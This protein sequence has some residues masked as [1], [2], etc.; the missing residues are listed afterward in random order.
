MHRLKQLIPKD[1]CLG[2]DVC[3]RFPQALSSQ[4]PYF[5]ASE[6]KKCPAF[7]PER[8][9]GTHITLTPYQEYFICPNFNPVLNKC[10]IYQ[11]RPF[12]CQLYPFTITYNSTNEEIVLGMD[13]KCPFVLDN[14]T[15]S[16]MENYK[17]HLIRYMCSMGVLNFISKNPKIVG[18]FQ[19][20]II[21]FKKLPI[22]PIHIKAKYH[23]L[24]T[25]TLKDKALFNK[26]FKK[27][28]CDLS[29]YSFTNIFICKDL[30]NIYYK[31][32][33]GNLC[34]FFNQA[35]TFFMIMP[36]L[37]NT[38]TLKDTVSICL[39]IMDDLNVGGSSSRIE[40]IHETLLP[41][42]KNL[43]YKIYKKYPEYIYKRKS[44]AELKGKKFKDKRN[45]I[46]FFLKNYKFKCIPFNGKLKEDCLNLYLK[47]ADK[48][49]ERPMDE[50]ALAM[51]K[52][53]LS[54]HKNIF[55]NYKRLGMSGIVVFVEDV[56][57]AYTFGFKLNKSAFCITAEVADTSIKGLAQ[58]IFREFCRYIEDPFINAMDDSGIENLKVTKMSYHPVKL[59][60]SYVATK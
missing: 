55:D 25:L 3:C 53:G 58:F 49:R 34:I 26:Y 42:F 20:D 36:P 47:W 48:K 40:N 27:K 15:K 13:T 45:L 8:T 30:F 44:L 35:N 5:S 14:Q 9:K 52:D 54:I 11:K 51:L 22:N 56:V 21:V 28:I 50:M 46:N 60:E 12:D 4:R 29:I 37:G 1:F 31:I 2:C 7:F 24:K 6:I 16:I 41:Q 39:D 57:L 10:T 43:E 19:N 59:L 18:A 32:I 33:N 38:A 23:N 17:R